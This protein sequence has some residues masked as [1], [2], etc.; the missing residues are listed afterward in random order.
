MPKYTNDIVAGYVLYF[1][2]KCVIEAMHVHASDKEL[3]EYGSAKLFVYSNGETRIMR[4]G[5]VCETDMN[6]IQAYIRNN[7]EV[8]Y[9]KWAMYSD[10]GFYQGD[11]NNPE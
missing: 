3:S 1:T 11:E 8:M 7:Y 9:R 6:K 10:N 5:T 4:W 2:S